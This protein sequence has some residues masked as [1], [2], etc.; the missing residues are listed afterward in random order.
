MKSLIT[1]SA[2]LCLVLGVITG[3]AACADEPVVEETVVEEVVEEAPAD[4]EEA[5]PTATEEK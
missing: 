3:L 5:A 4:T 2:L 1:K